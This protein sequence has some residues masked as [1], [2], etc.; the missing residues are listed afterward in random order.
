MSVCGISVGRR[1]CW[2]AAQRT[3]NNAADGR[4]IGPITTRRTHP[5]ALGNLILAGTVLISIMVDFCASERIRIL[6][7]FSL[8]PGNHTDRTGPGQVRPLRRNIFRSVLNCAMGR[9]EKSAAVCS[10]NDDQRMRKG[11]SS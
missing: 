6:L 1:T 4:F 9:K 5:E 7:E 8:R 2:Y 11:P 10:N 3:G